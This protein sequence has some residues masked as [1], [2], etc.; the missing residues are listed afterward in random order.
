M[1]S[2]RF[3]CRGRLPARGE[4][5]LLR[6]AGVAEDVNE[7]RAYDETELHAAHRDRFW[8]ARPSSR[9]PR[10]RR[11]PGPSSLGRRAAA[12]PRRTGAAR[13]QKSVVITSDL[14]RQEQPHMCW[15][16]SCEVARRAAYACGL[17][18]CTRPSRARMKVPRRSGIRCLPPISGANNIQYNGN[19]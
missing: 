6:G 5:Q 1:A 7:G 15:R 13:N 2:V 19:S 9:C 12:T 14:I 17:S 18:A 11:S 8:V 16:C 4:H 10:G 3:A